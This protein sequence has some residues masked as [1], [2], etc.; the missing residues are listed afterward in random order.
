MVL[1]PKGRLINS[2]LDAVDVVEPIRV[3]C[4]CC[5]HNWIYEKTGMTH[6]VS[7]TSCMRHE[8]YEKAQNKRL[9]SYR[10]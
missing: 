2:H 10:V 4:L 6:K 9:T 5:E 8:M 1:T 3:I 7:P